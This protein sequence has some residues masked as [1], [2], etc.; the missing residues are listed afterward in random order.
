VMRFGLRLRGFTLVELLVVMAIISLLAGMLLPVLG[1]ALSV[2]RAATCTNNLKQ[3]AMW[4]LQYADDNSEV[5]PVN[6]QFY[7]YITRIYNWYYHPPYGEEVGTGQLTTFG[8][9]ALVCPQAAS[10]LKPRKDT[11]PIDYGLSATLG[12]RH[13]YS[14]F[15]TPRRRLLTS[16]K[17]WFC[18]TKAGTDYGPGIYNQWNFVWAKGTAGGYNPWMYSTAFGGNGLPGHPHQTANYVFGDGHTAALDEVQVG[19]LY[20]ADG[21]LTW[22]GNCSQ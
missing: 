15:D 12:G 22:E 14:N 1:R 6:G 11:V 10:G 5:L 2:A 20:N 8:K 7:D 21:G 17:Y 16:R 9:K 3:I 18:D 19:N 4:G 13:T